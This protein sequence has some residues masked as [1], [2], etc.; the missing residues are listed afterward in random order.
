MEK[1]LFVR[2][3]SG[4]RPEMKLFHMPFERQYFEITIEFK[5]QYSKNNS[6]SGPNPEGIRC[7]AVEKRSRTLDLHFFVPDLNGGSR[8]FFRSSPTS[9]HSLAANEQI[10]STPCCAAAADHCCVDGHFISP[11]FS[12]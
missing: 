10:T 12:F 9:V 1:D 5:R 4:L 2:G 11:L 6:I 3:I 8:S 7:H